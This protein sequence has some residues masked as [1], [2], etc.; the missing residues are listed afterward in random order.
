VP[1]HLE[2]HAPLH[3]RS[4]RRSRRVIRAADRTS[5]GPVTR[6]GEASG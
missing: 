2:R 4:H 6:A 3:A 5:V 1:S